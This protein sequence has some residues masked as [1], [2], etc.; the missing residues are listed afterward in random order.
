MSLTTA[1]IK[2]NF[3]IIHYHTNAKHA[4]NYVN[5]NSEILDQTSKTVKNCKKAVKNCIKLL[6]TV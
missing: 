2:H 3:A 6:K 5:V 4:A 1:A